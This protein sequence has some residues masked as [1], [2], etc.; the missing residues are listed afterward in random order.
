MNHVNA[1]LPPR[2]RA[3]RS[4][5]ARAGL[6]F[7]AWCFLASPVA[8][9][10]LKV[11]HT[12]LRSEPAVL[13]E[14]IT[15]P[16]K[17]VRSDRHAVYNRRLVRLS[18][19]GAERP[20]YLVIE[21]LGSRGGIFEWKGI[22]SGM[23]PSAELFLHMPLRRLNNQCVLAFE[24]DDL[25]ES[26]GELD[27]VAAQQAELKDWKLD[28]EGYVVRATYTLTSGAIMTVLA[29]VPKPFAGL[30]VTAPL[31]KHES[32]LPEGVIAWAIKLGDEV[33]TGVS[34]ISG[35][36]QLPPIKQQ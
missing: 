24:S 34:S 25:G 36:W 30:P 15:L 7:L 11:G 21:E 8:A 28:S 35:Q 12:V 20:S 32:K 13:I 10:E 4:R 29:M 6:P 27:K 3:K 14:S 23:K 9:G 19:A 16:Q 31:P 26:L 17:E 22:C 1:T 33:K 2:T 5:T 18:Q